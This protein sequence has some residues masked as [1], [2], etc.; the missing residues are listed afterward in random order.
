M[1]LVVKDPGWSLSQIGLGKNNENYNTYII[2]IT[3]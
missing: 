3:N 2:Y 1:F